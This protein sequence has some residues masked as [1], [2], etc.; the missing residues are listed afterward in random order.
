MEYLVNPRFIDF[1]LGTTLPHITHFTLSLDLPRLIARLPG[2]G[3]L[4]E[5]CRVN[6]IRDDA[7]ARVRFFITPFPQVQ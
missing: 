6:P 4:G 7:D 2:E 3:L 5:V 1:D